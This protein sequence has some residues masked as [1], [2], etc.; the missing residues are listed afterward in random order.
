VALDAC[1]N[2]VDTCDNNPEDGLGHPVWWKM[3]GSRQ[4]CTRGH[5]NNCW[6]VRTVLLGRE[7]GNSRLLPIVCI[8]MLHMSVP[9]HTAG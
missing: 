7:P 4:R 9:T 6:I 5:P 1:A 3:A 2:N 8:D